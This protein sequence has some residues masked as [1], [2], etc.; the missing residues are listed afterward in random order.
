[1]SSP[2]RANIGWPQPSNRSSIPPNYT[3]QA[4][5]YALLQEPAYLSGA[6][7]GWSIAGMIVLSIVFWPAAMAVSIPLIVAA[8]GK[9]RAVGVVGAVISSIMVV[10]TLLLLGI[11]WATGPTPS[12]P[13]GAPAG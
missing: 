6:A 5:A 10:F 11:V 4:P 9:Y 8:D 13:L 12:A 1:M 3:S 7:L 2:N